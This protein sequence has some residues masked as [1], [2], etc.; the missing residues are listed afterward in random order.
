[1]PISVS[2]MGTKKSLAPAVANIVLTSPPGPILDVFSG[3]CAVAK[4]VAPTRQTWTNDFQHFAQSV[5]QAHFCSKS[6]PP[7]RIDAVANLARNYSLQVRVQ[8]KIA[9][10]RISQE[11]AALADEDVEKLNSTY[12]SWSELDPIEGSFHETGNATLFRDRFAGSYFGLLQCI[13]IDALRSSIDS[14][15][16]DGKFDDDEHRWLVLALA[17]AI[18][19]CSNSTGHFA[20]PLTPKNSNIRRFGLQRQRSVKECFL[21]ALET[22]EPVGNT[23][24]RSR[25]IAMRGDAVKAVES[26]KDSNMEKPSVV[27][28]DPPYTSDQYSR[29]YHLYETLVLYDYPAAVGKGRYRIDRSV[30]DFCL[31]TRV[32]KAFDTLINNCADIGADL[33]LSYPTN[34]LLDNSREIIPQKIRERYGREP[35]VLE[36]EHQHSTMGASKGPGK[37]NV[38]EVIYRAY[39]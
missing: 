1:M 3:L 22:L 9:R 8:E 21:S 25:N 18:N 19:R 33:V 2:Y 11:N 24:W 38:T 6:L 5:A 16:A 29:Y 27:Y 35:Q 13:E 31:T 12:L 15:L 36:I 39:C 37:K 34:G 17:V 4:S 7:Q 28:A 32:S 14:A 20:Q 26:F 30:S 23:D 10:D